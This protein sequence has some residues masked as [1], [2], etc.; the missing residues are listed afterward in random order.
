VLFGLVY[1]TFHH[2][3]PAFSFHLLRTLN[4]DFLAGVLA[5][6]L[7]R[8]LSYL[9]SWLLIPVGLFGY[10]NTFAGWLI[11]FSGSCGGFAL[12]AGL[13]NARWPWH[14]RPFRWLTTIGDASY[15]LYL[16][17][18]VVIWVFVKLMARL[19]TPPTWTA[20]PVRFVYLGIC[21][22]LAIKAY[23]HIE[24]PMIKLGNRLAAQ[25]WRIQANTAEQ[26]FPAENVS[27]PQTIK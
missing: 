27:E 23:H 26:P 8:P 16:I 6:L 21:V 14:A 10:Y 12:V 25:P 20:E 4:A 2:Y 18:F 17:H 22:W 1:W 9:P 7:R 15:S 11:P 13:A 24:R 19:G 5:Y 3:Q